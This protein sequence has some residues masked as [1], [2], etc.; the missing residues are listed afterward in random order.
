[1][2]DYEDLRIRINDR[3]DVHDLVD[4]LEIT[5]DDILDEFKD[6]VLENI[7]NI[8]EELGYSFIIEEVGEELE[9]D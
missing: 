7:K 3:L 5:A 6:K 4:L 9:I 2:I 8:H 1:M